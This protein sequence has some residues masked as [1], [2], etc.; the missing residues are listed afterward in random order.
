MSIDD[1]EARLVCAL[2][3]KFFSQNV[4]ADQFA[5][6][7]QTVLARHEQAKKEGIALS[8]ESMAALEEMIC[9]AEQEAKAG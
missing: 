1:M 4:A 3:Q 8:P 7:R 9:E 2:V 6:M 5:R